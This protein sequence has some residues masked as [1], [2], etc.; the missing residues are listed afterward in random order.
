MLPN[1]LLGS[2]MLTS[3]LYSSV[4]QIEFNNLFLTGANPKKHALIRCLASV[5]Y[6]PNHHNEIFYLINKLDLNLKEI[7]QSYIDYNLDINVYGNE[8]YESLSI[9]IVLHILNKL[10]R[11]WRQERQA[12]VLEY[13]LLSKADTAIDMGFG[14]PSS[15]VKYDLFAELFDNQ[16]GNLFVFCDKRI[17]S[18]N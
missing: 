15:Y 14:V 2:I 16:F 5:L 18:I 10:E 17:S 3:D 9:R 1:T 13:L 11:S 12:T 6:H 7:V 4:S 8:I